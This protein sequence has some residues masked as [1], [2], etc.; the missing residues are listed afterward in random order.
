MYGHFMPAEY[1]I[2]VS[3]FRNIQATHCAYVGMSVAVFMQ[4]VNGLH[5]TTP[6]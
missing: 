5:A 4:S 1:F 6:F 3:I 2:E